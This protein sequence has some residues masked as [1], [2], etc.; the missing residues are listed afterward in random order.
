MRLTTPF[1]SLFFFFQTDPGKPALSKVE[2][3]ERDVDKN[4]TLVQVLQIVFPNLNYAYSFICFNFQVVFVKMSCEYLA[5]SY[6]TAFHRSSFSLN[7]IV[8]LNCTLTSWEG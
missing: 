2:V 8:S 7:L 1:P 6:R 4:C 3:L 5:E